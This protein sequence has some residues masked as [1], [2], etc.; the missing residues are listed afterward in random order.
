MAICLVSL[1][2]LLLLVIRPKK[3]VANSE[4]VLIREGRRGIKIRGKEKEREREENV[5]TPIA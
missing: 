3:G 1:V 5:A 2:Y 4:R